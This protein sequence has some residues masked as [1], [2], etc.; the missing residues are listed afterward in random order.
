[1]SG[2][3]APRFVVM[4]RKW[5]FWHVTMETPYQMMVAVHLAQ[6]TQATSAAVA[7]NLP[8]IRAVKYV[9]MEES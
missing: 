3:S 4:A 8:Q 9:V 7:P 5:A 1:M 6:L 2:R